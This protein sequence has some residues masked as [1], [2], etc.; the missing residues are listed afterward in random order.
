MLLF[1]YYSGRGLLTRIISSLDTVY[2]SEFRTRI[3]C[4]RLLEIGAFF[5]FLVAYPVG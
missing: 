5:D 2:G 3:G 4:S 1:F